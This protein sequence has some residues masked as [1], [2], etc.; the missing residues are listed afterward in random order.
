V[1]NWLLILFSIVETS[2]QG[3]RWRI[4]PSARAQEPLGPGGHLLRVG[5]RWA[6]FGWLIG[7]DA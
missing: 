1:I 6:A 5:Q 3:D 2:R 7:R 4:V